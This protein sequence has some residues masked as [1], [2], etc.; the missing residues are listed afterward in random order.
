MASLWGKAK[1]GLVATGQELMFWVEVV[2]EWMQ[3]DRNQFDDVV[4]EYNQS[5]EMKKRDND[6]ERRRAAYHK[7]EIRQ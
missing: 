3:W 2:G 6:L 5:I 7:T 4:E 1:S